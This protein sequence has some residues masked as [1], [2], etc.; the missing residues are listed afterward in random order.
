MKAGSR[1]GS[2]P[3]R[4]KILAHLIE[5]V[6]RKIFRAYVFIFLTGS[7]RPAILNPRKAPKILGTLL[8]CYMLG[9]ALSSPKKF[10]HTLDRVPAIVG[11]ACLPSE[12]QIERSRARVRNQVE[13]QCYVRKVLIQPVLNQ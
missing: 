5:L 11:V 2:R 8:S 4:A 10:M 13:N 12:A 1:F 3:I 9:W 6:K 7:A